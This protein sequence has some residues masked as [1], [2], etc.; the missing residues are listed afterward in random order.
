MLIDVNG[1]PI[2][3]EVLDPNRVAKRFRKR[4]PKEYEEASKKCFRMAQFGQ[5]CNWPK[6]ITDDLI[7][8]AV[9]LGEVYIAKKEGMIR[10]V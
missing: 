6:N 9:L 7:N 4:P 1:K 5:R 2:T 3:A 8:F 10:D